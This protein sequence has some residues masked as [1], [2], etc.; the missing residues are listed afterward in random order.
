M[1]FELLQKISS[2]EI[3]ACNIMQPHSRVAKYTL[4]EFNR[5]YRHYNQVTQVDV[6]G[7]TSRCVGAIRLSGCFLSDLVAQ[8]MS[9]SGVSPNIIS[10]NAAVSS[11]ESTGQW[12]HAAG[13]LGTRLGH[14]LAGHVH[15]S[16]WILKIEAM[17]GDVRT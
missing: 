13:I 12:Q 11:C 5:L 15:S 4:I 2:A 14:A 17:V 8:R 1:R 16:H 10:F 9:G 6:S 3:W 7:H